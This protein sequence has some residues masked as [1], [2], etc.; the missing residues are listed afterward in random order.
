MSGKSE[1][2]LNDDL[3]REALRLEL[4]SIEAPPAG[5]VW[6]RIEAGLDQTRPSFRRPVF[7]WSRLAA[8]AAVFLVI[9]LGGISVYRIMQ[10]PSPSADFSELPVGSGEE[11]AMLE[12][13][14]AAEVE[15]D[16][17]VAALIE[18]DA[19]ITDDHTA[20]IEDDPM[21]AE[22]DL[23]TAGAVPSLTAEPDPSPPDWPLPVI[24]DLV[25]NKTI[26]LSAAGGPEYQGALYSRSDAELL[27][28]N[29]AVADEDLTLFIDYLGRYIDFDLQDSGKI[30]GFTRLTAAELPGL[31]W[32]KDGRNQALLVISGL[33]TTEELINIAA[34]VE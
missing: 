30:N 3:I 17:G 7:G 12:A 6:Q 13:D 24:E 25:L 27:W 9:V 31:A 21:N 15:E 16:V 8:V 28:V 26:I 19:G 2:K 4:E 20:I 5:K 1:L 29:S 34:A 18:D 14:D 22:N 32:Q 11:V 33:L 10:F 23:R